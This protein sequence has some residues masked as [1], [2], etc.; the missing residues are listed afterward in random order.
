[1]NV[2]KRTIKASAMAGITDIIIGLLA[3]F[4]GFGDWYYTKFHMFGVI[5]FG[6]LAYAYWHLY[7]LRLDTG[8]GIW[9]KKK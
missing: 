4:T 6:M 3:Y 2:E 5:G 8:E 9:K 7:F 1:M